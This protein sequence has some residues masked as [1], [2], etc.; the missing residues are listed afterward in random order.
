MV[1]EPSTTMSF[2]LPNTQPSFSSTSHCK[3]FHTTLC[4]RTV[5]ANNPYQI[6][7]SRGRLRRNFSK[8]ST[9]ARCPNVDARPDMK[10]SKVSYPAEFPA[11]Q[12]GT[13]ASRFV[14]VRHGALFIILIYIGVFDLTPCETVAKYFTKK[15]YCMIRIA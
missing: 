11:P 8:C 3:R 10:T 12:S 5:A 1:F 4:M 2:V 6:S 7:L 15:H 9:V 14:L 13:S